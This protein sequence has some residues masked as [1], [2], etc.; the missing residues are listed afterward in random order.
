MEGTHEV[1]NVFHDH[2]IE[3]SG[4]RAGLG[5]NQEKNTVFIRIT[6]FVRIRIRFSTHWTPKTRNF[7]I[8]VFVLYLR[9]KKMIILRIS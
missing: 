8:Y 3:T 5:G 1:Y 7:S 4:V 2:S 6:P 9:N